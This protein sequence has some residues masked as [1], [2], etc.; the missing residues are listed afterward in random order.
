M[1]N[2]GAAILP[3]TH[4][5]LG[6][7][8]MMGARAVSALAAADSLVLVLEA[9]VCVR[10]CVLASLPAV[11]FLS[12]VFSPPIY[13]VRVVSTTTTA[14]SQSVSFRSFLRGSPTQWPG[15][16]CSRCVF[17]PLGSWCAWTASGHSSPT[18]GAASPVQRG[19]SSGWVGV[20]APLFTEQPERVSSGTQKPRCPE[21]ATKFSNAPN[22]SV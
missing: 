7:R 4:P 2:G 18:S 20:R 10:Q 14:A 8:M 6:C 1:A 17:V 11:R 9:T 12:V 16:C 3:T 13:S 15:V 21:Q 22:R 19:A 5:P